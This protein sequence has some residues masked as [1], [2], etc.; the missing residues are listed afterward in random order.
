MRLKETIAALSARW[1]PLTFYQRFEDVIIVLLTGLIAVVIV[2]AVWSLA[3]KVILGV[4]PNGLDFTDYA[5][6][7][8]IFGMIFTVIIAL[9]FRRS[10]VVLQKRHDSIVQVRTVVLIALLAV[11]RK[12]M[13][14]DIATTDPAQLFGLAAAIMALGGVHWLVREQ[15]RRASDDA[16]AGAMR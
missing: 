8:A 11:V 16:V 10:L 2:M 7:Q 12:L 5:V 4:L 9:E 1:S 14:V 3:V 6:F 13:I 15:D